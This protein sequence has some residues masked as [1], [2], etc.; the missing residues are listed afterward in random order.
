MFPLA[1]SE[2]DFVATKDK[3]TEFV[4]ARTPGVMNALVL[5]LFVF[6]IVF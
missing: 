4:S 1:H 5:V 6:K 2:L 3:C